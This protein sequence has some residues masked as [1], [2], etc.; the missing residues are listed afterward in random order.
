[1]AGS[2]HMMDKDKV[3][4]ELR[5]DLDQGLRCVVQT[6]C[7]AF[8]AFDSLSSRRSENVRQKLLANDETNFIEPPL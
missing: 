6:R 4:K 2:L 3:L 7:E 1:M 8:A 5:S